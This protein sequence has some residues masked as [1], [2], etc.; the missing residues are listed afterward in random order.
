M[1]RTLSASGSTI[2]HSLSHS[3]IVDLQL[4][5]VALLYTGHG[6]NQLLLHA[7]RDF[8][9]KNLVHIEFL[10]FRGWSYVCVART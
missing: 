8:G 7:H 10:K 5:S 2:V 1:T 6:V 9:V 3:I 4:F